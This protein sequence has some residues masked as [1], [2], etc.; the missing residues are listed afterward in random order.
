[1]NFNRLK[2][3]RENS[4]QQEIS[5]QN[6][7]M[8]QI[9]DGDTATL[10][11]SGKIDATNFQVIQDATMAVLNTD[12]IQ[13]LVF[14]TETV[15]YVSSAGLRMF[16]AINLQAQSLKKGYRAINMRSDIYKMFQ[17]MGYGNAFDITTKENEAT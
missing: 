14:D 4:S 1:M 2:K 16:N 13:N 17:L 8:T 9:I 11:L 7:L 5:V 10:V 15:T 3:N 12:T 6:G